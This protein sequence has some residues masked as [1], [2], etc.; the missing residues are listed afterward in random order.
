M[1]ILTAMVAFENPGSGTI[2]KADVIEREGKHWLVPEWLENLQEGWRSPLRIVLLDVLPHQV[3]TGSAFGDF[4]LTSPIRRDIFDGKVPASA[5]P[6]YVVV[7]GPDS[8]FPL[9]TRAQ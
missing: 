9:P 2:Y 1:K 4:V 8:R 5:D 3:T 6:R 7:E